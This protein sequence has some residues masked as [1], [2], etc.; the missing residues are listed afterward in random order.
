MKDE[1]RQETVECLIHPSSFKVQLLLRE[2]APAEVHGPLSSGALPKGLIF[3]ARC[4]CAITPAHSIA[5]QKRYHYYICT[6]K[7]KRGTDSCLARALSAGTIENFV[8]E[9]IRTL[10]HDPAAWRLASWPQIPRS[11]PRRHDP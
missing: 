8:V 9:Q 10:G 7:Q 4:G 11:G 3:C 5:R 2:N 6:T 1:E